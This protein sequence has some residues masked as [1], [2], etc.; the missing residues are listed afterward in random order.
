[1][2][3]F[4]FAE[5]RRRHKTNRR[6]L[7][8][9][10]LATLSQA[11]A[12]GCNTSDVSSTQK[13]AESPP[14]EAEL[15]TV[16]PRTWPTI[17]RSQGSLVADEVSVIGAK[18][19]GQV[20]EVD[21][22]LGD[23]VDAG[24]ALASLDQNEFRLAVA[25]AEAQLAQARSA[26]G[27]QPGDALDQLDPTAAAPVRQEAAIW[28]E[29][30]A[31]LKR[32]EELQEQ[33]VI[34]LEEMEQ[35]ASAEKVAAARYASALNRVQENI[36]LVS[37]RQA[38][39]ALAQEQLADSVFQAPFAGVIQQRHASPGAF[40]QVG[41]P[42]ATLVR[43]HPL[44]FRGTIP[45]RRA[46]NLAVGQEVV[47]M[48]ESIETPIHAAV[49]RI[50]PSLNDATRALT[51]EAMV[52]NP[53]GRLRVGLFAE[54]QVVVDPAAETIIVPPSALVEFAGAEKVWKVVEGVAA[55][56]V[57]LTGERRP[58]GIQILSGLS[59]GDVVLVR[60]ERGRVAE[61]RPLAETTEG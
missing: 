20:A 51:F 2:P 4:Q 41:D 6:N 13:T 3:T 9:V 11:V 22:D 35:I 16:Q 39:L 40:V 31:R 58:E 8:V 30:K 14:L 45:E 27:L 48:V 61:V 29:T 1:M 37:V 28:N 44:R 17:V 50:S 47:L 15:L 5:D 56:Q 21:V 49:T 12:I 55:E 7:V 19:A 26:V 34:T 23:V 57:V 38:E 25:R 33:E 53:D 59:A 24:G 54:A 18:V 10:V 43:T 42:I 32:A 52:D 60:G 36:A 46:R